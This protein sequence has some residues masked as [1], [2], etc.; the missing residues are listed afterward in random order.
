[1][2][3]TKEGPPAS[4]RKES[5]II[6]GGDHVV[7]PSVS[8]MLGRSVISGEGLLTRSKG[9]VVYTGK[10]TGRSPND[11]FFV[12]GDPTLS[13][14]LDSR[15]NGTFARGQYDRLVEKVNEYLTG[16]PI[17]IQHLY[18]GA[19][20]RYRLSLEVAT[21]TSWQALFARN[22]FRR[23]EPADLLN[24]KPD[25]TVVDVSKFK[26]QPNSDGTRSEAF[27]FID[28][29]RNLVLIGETAY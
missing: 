3:R 29:R 11:K 27:I 21:D 9:L 23:P 13:S 18:A 14:H 4:L 20:S 17:V 19:D 26:A 7:N 12:D 5:G 25:W 10:Y 28:T 8:D 6:L 15:R 1:M 2:T 22:L 24:F 16:E